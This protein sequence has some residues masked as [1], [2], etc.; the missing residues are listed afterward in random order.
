MKRILILALV[1]MLAGPEAIA[2]E[3]CRVV[4]QVPYEVSTAGKYCLVANLATSGTLGVRISADDVEFDCAGHLID[5]LAAQDPNSIGIH[6]FGNNIRISNCTIKG[7][8]EGVRVSGFGNS[9]EDNR[10]IGPMFI[11]LNSSGESTRIIDNAIFDVGGIPLPNRAEFGVVSIG[12]AE[13]TG[14]SVNG[15][16]VATGMARSA[17]GL[18]SA[19][20]HAGLVRDN[21][22]R[23]LV[24]DDSAINM[25]LMVVGSE[26][27][28][29]QRNIVTN[30]GGQLG[31][32]IYCTGNGIVSEQNIVQGYPYGVT[33][34]CRE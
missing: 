3:N 23:A 12:D 34:A 5:G 8:G 11:G 31:W 6:A 21:V 24:S 18:Y 1:A 26:N 10:I 25:A 32:A 7:F 20:N 22:I 4:D 28:V 9:V 16:A 15:V 33:G 17:Y 19:N 29:I 2:A 13:I 27:I 14:N 30:F